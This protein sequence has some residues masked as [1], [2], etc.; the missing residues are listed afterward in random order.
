MTAIPG[1][2]GMIIAMLRFYGNHELVKGD[3]V[4]FRRVELALRTIAIALR[5]GLNYRGGAWPYILFPQ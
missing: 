4:K 2:G 5:E 1:S 3:I